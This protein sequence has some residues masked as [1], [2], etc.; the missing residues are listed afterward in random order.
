VFIKFLTEEQ[1]EVWSLTSTSTAVELTLRPTDVFNKIREE[2]ATD[3]N[4]NDIRRAFKDLVRI[5]RAVLKDASSES[6]V[7]SF[8]NLSGRYLRESSGQEGLDQKETFKEY[9]RLFAT[10]L[11]EKDLKSGAPPR[12]LRLRSTKPPINYPFLPFEK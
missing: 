7:I 4:I 2:Y 8:A 9:G 5:K 11:A 12:A 10:L 3:I 6:H 1:F